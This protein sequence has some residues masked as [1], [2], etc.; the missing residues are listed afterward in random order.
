MYLT[1][2]LCWVAAHIAPFVLGVPPANA[3]TPA[4]PEGFEFAGKEGG[5]L[6]GLDD[7]QVQWS[8]LHTLCTSYAPQS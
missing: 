3:A 6:G 8:T 5:G 1:L 4:L 2:A 7:I